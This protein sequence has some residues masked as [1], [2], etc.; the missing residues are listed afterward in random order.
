VFALWGLGATGARQVLVLDGAEHVWLTATDGR[1]EL[2]AEPSRGYVE[3]VAAS[4]IFPR[5][6]PNL[7]PVKG[8][9]PV[10]PGPPH[11]FP[12]RDAAAIVGGTLVA[13]LGVA[14]AVAEIANGWLGR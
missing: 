6:N 5:S 4:P 13:L 12:A 1:V 11:D 9:A 8:R 14:L 2:V 3:V 10:T 7:S